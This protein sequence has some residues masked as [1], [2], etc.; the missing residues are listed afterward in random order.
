MKI[1]FVTEKV[2]N[3][4]L[5]RFHNSEGRQETAVFED[6]VKLEKFLKEYLETKK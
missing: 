2:T 5:C 1:Q 6:Y 4:Y 3:G